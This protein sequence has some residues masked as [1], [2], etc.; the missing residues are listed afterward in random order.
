MDASKK[1]ASENKIAFAAVDAHYGLFPLHLLFF[2]MPC[3][4]TACQPFF[5]PFPSDL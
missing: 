2:P 1:E 4:D 3:T 5:P